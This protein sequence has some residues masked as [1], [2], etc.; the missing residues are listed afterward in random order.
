MKEKGERNVGT[1]VVKR[2][3]LAVLTV[4]I[5]CAITFFTMLIYCFLFGMVLTFIFA[6]QITPKKSIFDEPDAQ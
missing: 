1:Y 6:P 4:F 5:I 3:L 2:I